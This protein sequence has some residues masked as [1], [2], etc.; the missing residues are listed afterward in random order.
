MSNHLN[1]PIRLCESAGELVEHAIDNGTNR[2][3]I[4]RLW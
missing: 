1:R 3:R 2:L 4:G